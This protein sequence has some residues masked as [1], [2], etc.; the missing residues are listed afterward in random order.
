MLCEDTAPGGSLLG[1]TLPM[2]HF[3]QRSMFKGKGV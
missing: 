2:S 3:W 1:F